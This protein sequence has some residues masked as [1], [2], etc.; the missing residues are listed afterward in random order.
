LYSFGAELVSGNVFISWE[1]VSELNNDYFVVE[2]S[3]DGIHFR[4]IGVVKGKGNSKSLL[5]YNLIDNQPVSGMSYY[6]L[7]Q[8]DYDGSSM[9]VS[10]VAIINNT[11]KEEFDLQ[12]YP[13][14]STGY[15][16][17]NVSMPALLKIIS[18][19]GKEIFCKQ[20]SA[21]NNKIYLEGI[22][23]GI[24]YVKALTNSNVVIKKLVVE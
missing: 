3:V 2:R 9:V 20:L 4:S 15:L 11:S 5:K 6:R 18:F 14:P 10:N 12:V 8:V 1:T 16:F 19:N 23:S 24:Y 22:S 13:N 17:V 7:T 21:G